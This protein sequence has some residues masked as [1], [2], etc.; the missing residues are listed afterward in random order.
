[1]IGMTSLRSLLL[2]CMWSLGGVAGAAEPPR[3]LSQAIEPQ[4]L[5]SALEALGQQTGLMFIFVSSVAEAQQSKGAPAGLAPPAAL[6]AVLEGTGLQ[7]EFLNA[8]TVRV[9]VASGKPLSV[10]AAPANDRA[11]RRAAPAS[12]AL[13]EVVV[14]GIRGNEP[15]NRVAIDMAVWTESAMESSGI[16]GISQIAD[17]TPGL[18]FS[19]RSFVGGDFQ[20][21]LAIRGVAERHG[22]TVGIYL[23]DTQIPPGYSVSYLRSFPVTLDLDRVEVL[24]GPQGTLLGDHTQG[25]AIR[26]VTNQPSLTDLTAMVRT[27]ISATAH[28]GASYE[29]G[30]AVGGPVVEDLLGFRLSGWYRSDAGYVDRIDPLTAVTVEADANRYLTRSARA[31]LTLAPADTV[32]ISPALTYQSLNIHDTSSFDITLSDPSSGVLRNDSFQ[33]QPF[34]NSFYLASLKVAAGLSGADLSAVTAY[35]EGNSTATLDAS[36]GPG[37]VAAYYQAV[38]Q[39]ELSQ[40]LSFT[41]AD[42]N[43]RLTW[44]AGAFFSNNHNRISDR[45]VGMF[46]YFSPIPA[47]TDIGNETIIHKTSL[48]AFGDV[49]WKMTPHLTLSGGLRVGHT[50]FEGDTQL[51]PVFHAADADTWTAPRFVLSYQGTSQGL[52]YL[53]AAKG[54]GSGGVYYAFTLGPDPPGAYT[55]D[56]LWSYEAGA[57]LNLNGGRVSLD[58]SIFH[59][60]WNNG[61]QADYYPHAE[62]NGLVPGSA[63]SNGFDLAAQAFLTE[64]LLGRVDIAYTDARYTHTVVT[65]GTFVTVRAGDAVGLGSPWS[66]TSSLDRTFRLSSDL[67]CTLRVEDAFHSHNPRSFY[68]ENPESQYYQPGWRPDPSINILNARATVRWSPFEVAAFVNNALNSQPS[69]GLAL[70]PVAA[71]RGSWAHTVTPRT[72]GVSGTWRF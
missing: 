42:P 31:A 54:Y 10:L 60:L 43:A 26:Y 36:Q 7:Y 22:A 18:D 63:V 58:G 56:T 14:T 55:P 40:E 39:S 70:A 72:L 41:S 15:L 67:A 13:E 66:L 12:A 6:A 44:L 50:R 8:R 25:G 68:E 27:E 61:P 29:A 24:R 53:S 23:D 30:S 20:T 2:C 62:N 17:L 3:V 65:Y 48:E 64:H 28:G 11:P 45:L 33:P 69:L 46:A 21:N 9:F 5:A 1:M 47:P 37:A 51:P 34:D 71:V 16:K 59:I 4:P 32:R 52:L 38:K 49:S 57:K 19:F 35:F